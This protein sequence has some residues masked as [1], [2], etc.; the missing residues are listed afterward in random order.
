MFK[1]V[2]MF[3]SLLLLLLTLPLFGNRLKFLKLLKNTVRLTLLRFV[4]NGRRGRSLF[5]RFFPF[6]VNLITRNWFRFVLR[7]LRRGGGQLCK[8]N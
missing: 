4:L 8:S 6:G 5:S 3:I 7:R 2:F 1:P